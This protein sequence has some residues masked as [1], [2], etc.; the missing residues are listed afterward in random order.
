MKYL[1]AVLLIFTLFC[2]FGCS[3]YPPITG[4]VV[5]SATGK[6]IEGALVVAQWAKKHGFGLTYHELN[7]ITET[8]T[9]KEGSFSLSGNDDPSVEPPEMIIYKQG[10]VP[11]R[12]DS[13]FPS[14]NIV[15][16][17]EWKDKITYKL[18]VLTLGY[19]DRQV[20]DFLD[21]GTTISRGLKD[22]KMFTELMH[23][24]PM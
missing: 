2:C 12:N 1:S 20:Y 21:F 6:P 9:D 23:K 19:T 11:W 16:D 14:N 15:K 7:K 13:V 18:K 22:S 4:K 17:H 8:L 10:Y 24:L 3:H 5:D